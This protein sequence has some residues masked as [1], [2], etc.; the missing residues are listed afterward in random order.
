MKS[1]NILPYS[2]LAFGSLMTFAGAAFV[3]MYILEA[4]VARAGEPDQSLLF[5]YLPILFLGVIGMAIGLGVCA[6]G[7][8]RLRKQRHRK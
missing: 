4:I 8:I 5:W 2:A 1:N 6:W 3:V 7:I